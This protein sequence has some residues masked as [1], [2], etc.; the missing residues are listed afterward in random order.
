M[1]AFY[2]TVTENRIL[3]T[4]ICNQVMNFGTRFRHQSLLV[5]VEALSGLMS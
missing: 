2:T 3:V 4:T 1:V 5:H